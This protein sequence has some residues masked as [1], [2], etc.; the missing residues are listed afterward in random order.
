MHCTASCAKPG[1][2]QMALEMAIFI[3]SQIY[4][5]IT[6]SPL[7]VSCSL[8]LRSWYKDCYWTVYWPKMVLRMFWHSMAYFWMPEAWRG[9]K[10][11]KGNHFFLI[12]LFLWLLFWSIQYRLL[13]EIGVGSTFDLT[14]HCYIGIMKGEESINHHQPVL[15]IKIHNWKIYYLN[16][17]TCTH[18]QNQRILVLHPSSCKF[19]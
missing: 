3:T 1:T 19:Q 13:L 5:W 14:Q 7:G 4:I 16:A 8:W 9:S 12:D 17:C 18:I 10:K 11:I 15:T 6:S 2:W